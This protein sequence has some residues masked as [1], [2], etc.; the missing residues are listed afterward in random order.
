MYKILTP[1]LL[2]VAVTMPLLMSFSGHDRTGNPSPDDY[3]KDYFISPVK[4]PIH[5]TGTCGELRSNHFHSGADIDGVVGDPVYAAADGYV[6]RIKVLES[7]Y[8][9]VLYVKHPNGYSTVVCA[10]GSL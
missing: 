8:G 5:L 6:Y 4:G 3:P 7:G 2:F 1:V 10:F 9:N